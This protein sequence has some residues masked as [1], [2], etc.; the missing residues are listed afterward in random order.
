MSRTH[1]DVRRRLEGH[2]RTF[3]VARRQDE[4][5][6]VSLTTR[7]AR[8][9]ISKFLARCRDR[10]R[11]TRAR[12][13]GSLPQ[14][15]ASCQR[16]TPDRALRERE[17]KRARVLVEYITYYMYIRA[18]RIGRREECACS[19]HTEILTVGKP[20][21]VDRKKSHH[22]RSTCFHRSNGTNSI[23]SSSSFR[24]KGRAPF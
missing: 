24:R 8:W 2:G 5:G 3:Q 16:E 4:L 22:P 13:P 14:V 10:Y 6:P 1:G 18:R 9:P 17:C 21:S 23:V 7:A 20:R 11:A 19:F 15:V 12:S